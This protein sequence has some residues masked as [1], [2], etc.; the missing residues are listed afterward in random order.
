MKNEKRREKKKTTSKAWDESGDDDSDDDISNAFKAEGARRAGTAGD[1]KD[2]KKEKEE[3]KK[4]DDDEPA[5]PIDDAGQG[6]ISEA[7]PDGGGP[8]DEPIPI[9]PAVADKKDADE[10][11]TA[12]LSPVPPGPE[13]RDPAAP[14]ARP[15]PSSTTPATPATPEWRTATSR[16]PQQQKPHP[17]QGGRKGPIGLAHP[18]PIEPVNSRPP[19]SRQS[20]SRSKQSGGGGPKSQ[21]QSQSQIANADSTKSE[22]EKKEPR[23]RKEVKVRDSGMGS[24]ADRVKNLVIG[25]QGSEQKKKEKLD[26]TSRPGPEA[27]A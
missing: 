27:P 1:L 13:S 11:E 20:S 15:T 21:S 12:I 19:R 26:T 17:I 4:D 2:E 10:E 5:W 6:Q 14:T 8:P 18:P 16:R 3:E 22:S 24:L 25:T 23:V 9:E 7:A